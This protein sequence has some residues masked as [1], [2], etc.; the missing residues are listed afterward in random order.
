MTDIEI[1]PHLRAEIFE[2]KEVIVLLERKVENL[3]L[4]P[5]K[6]NCQTEKQA[7]RAGYTIALS[8]LYGPSAMPIDYD[9]FDKEVAR[10]YKKWKK[11]VS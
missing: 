8:Y 10:A 9:A 7:F 3:E 1:M 4:L 2:L 5:C 6:F 11:S